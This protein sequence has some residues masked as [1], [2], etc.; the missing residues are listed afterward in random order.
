MTEVAANGGTSAH[1]LLIPSIKSLKRTYELFLASQGVKIP[2]MDMDSQR[3][4]L[5]S[6]VQAE[7]ASVKDL[8]PPTAS[9][10]RA[11]VPRNTAN[12]VAVVDKDQ[13]KAVGAPAAPPEFVD[14][15]DGT[16]VVGGFSYPSRPGVNLTEDSALVASVSEGGFD[17]ILQ[18]LPNSREEERRKTA[19][20]LV[21]Y[22]QAAGISERI[23]PPSGALAHLQPIVY[24]KPEWHAPWK[25]MRVISGHTGWVK[26]ISVDSSNEWF[27]TGSADRTIKI[28]DLASGTLKLTLTGHINTVR[29]IA[30]S[31]RHPYL[32][33]CGEDKMVKSWDLEYNKVIRQYHG[34]LS[35]VYCLT[36]H[37]TIDVLVT[38]GRDSTARVWD[39]RTKAQ[40]HVLTGHSSTVCA[41]ASQGVDPQIIS[42]SHDS[43]IRL[44]DLAAGSSMAVLTNHKK[45][46]RALALHPNEFSFA[47][48][49][50][51]N[52]KQ[53]K[54][55]QGNFLK[56]MSGHNAI[57]NSISVNQ[58]NVLVS[59]A[60]NGSMYFWDW[61]T[62]YNFQTMA[63]TPQPGSLDSEAGIYTSCFDQSGTRFITGEADKTIKIWKEDENA[64][65]E[66]HPVVNWRPARNKKRY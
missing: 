45:S 28:W 4:K 59:S 43:T 2:S 47:S 29:G 64:T 7:Y 6:K 33:S 10:S 65:P 32:F 31:P 42:G 62:G 5:Y 1:S 56:N 50:P 13:D 40:V 12:E 25:L 58:D 27:A 66:T 35:A 54:F 51:D 21:E 60:D 15:E 20:G 23:N 39:I 44:W 63:T 19:Y 11:V 17:K 48:G 18:T 36:L 22:R 55:P 37:P 53:W 61:K 16:R 24:E 3:I 41:L 57:I 46:V 8:P 49:A 30:I 52:I 34:H 38:G 14:R 26:S 9:T